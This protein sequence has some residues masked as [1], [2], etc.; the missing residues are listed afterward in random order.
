MTLELSDELGELVED[1]RAADH[2]DYSYP[3][4]GHTR[5]YRNL[6]MLLRERSSVKRLPSEARVLEEDK[7][8][9]SVL[10]IAGIKRIKGDPKVTVFDEDSV[11]VGELTHEIDLLRG[12]PKRL[13][14]P[15]Q[16]ISAKQWP[17]PYSRWRA[18]IIKGCD[19][20]GYVIDGSHPELRIKGVSFTTSIDRPKLARIKRALTTYLSMEG[21]IYPEDSSDI[22]LGTT[23]GLEFVWVPDDG[24][25]VIRRGKV[26]TRFDACMGFAGYAEIGGERAFFFRDHLGFREAFVFSK[27]SR[28]S[29]FRG[30]QPIL[31]NCLDSDAYF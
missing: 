16:G 15:P 23:A 18:Q 30:D 7:Y 12:C 17:P 9:S 20:G 24:H 2:E 11:C 8:S 26:I 25:Y 5:R 19:E 6:L 29:I 10:Y 4:L 22:E 14:S 28:K 21:V 31:D 27:G 3:W 13:K 1:V